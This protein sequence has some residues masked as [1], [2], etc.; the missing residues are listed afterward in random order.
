MVLV[1]PTG[2]A[3]AVEPMVPYS[4]YS[5]NTH[6]SSDTRTDRDLL[7]NLGNYRPGIT[8]NRY[9]NEGN[10]TEAMLKASVIES[11]ILSSA[12]S[13][14]IASFFEEYFGSTP[15][16]NNDITPID[17]MAGKNPFSTSMLFETLSMLTTLTTYPNKNL[18]DVDLSS[19]LRLRNRR[20][21]IGVGGQL[22]SGLRIPIGGL[23]DNS[24]NP[25]SYF[26][27]FTI[28]F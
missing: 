1:A 14:S 11:N 21:G 2:L 19:I 23:Q 15:P 26:F 28:R 6:T 4:P 9:G 22:P 7:A 10:V 16:S 12:A 13:S 17:T 27:T 24:L 18:I 25:I 8:E 5:D 20:I 3:K